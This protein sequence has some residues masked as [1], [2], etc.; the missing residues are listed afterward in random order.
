[1][2]FQEDSTLHWRTVTENV[3]FGLE[4]AGVSGDERARLAQEMIE[5]DSLGGFEEHRPR[6]L[7]GGMSSASRLPGRS[8]STRASC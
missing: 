5:L 1:M 7:S 3:T 4:V 2:V 8:C 6:E